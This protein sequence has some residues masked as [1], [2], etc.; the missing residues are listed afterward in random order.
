MR[1]RRQPGG[2][3][4][5]LDPARAPNSI[6]MS[7]RS[8]PLSKPAHAQSRRALCRAIILPTSPPGAGARLPNILACAVIRDGS[9]ASPAM[10]SKFVASRLRSQNRCA[11]IPN[12]QGGSRA[13]L[14][15]EK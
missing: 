7:G 8:R 12:A 14:L 9:E 13:G 1:S 2:C 15:F 4:P 6:C 11:A 5:M 10:G 3:D